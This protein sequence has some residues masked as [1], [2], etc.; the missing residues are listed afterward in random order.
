MSGQRAFQAESSGVP[1]PVGESMLTIFKDKQ[2]GMNDKEVEM[3][4]EVKILVGIRGGCSKHS[5]FNA[6]GGGQSLQGFE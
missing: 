1:R 5:G 4:N 6:E 3:G 2:G